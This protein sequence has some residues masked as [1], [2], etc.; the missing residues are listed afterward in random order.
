MERSV[1]ATTAMQAEEGHVEIAVD[2]PFQILLVCR[3]QLR[4]RES[5]FLE[6]FTGSFARSE[7]HVAFPACS[8]G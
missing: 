1:F 4:D 2:E 5:R 3:I 8:T 6:G 7:R